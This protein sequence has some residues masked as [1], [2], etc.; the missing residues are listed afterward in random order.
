MTPLTNFRVLT[1]SLDYDDAWRYKYPADQ[2]PDTKYH[3]IQIGIEK[4]DN[5]DPTGV[6]FVVKYEVRIISQISD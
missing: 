5:N 6:K 4:D 2:E 1:E 3:T